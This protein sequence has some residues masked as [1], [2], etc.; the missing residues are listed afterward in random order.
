MK[1]TTFLL[2]LV[3]AIV[4]LT[5]ASWGLASARVADML[6]AP[7]PNM[8]KLRTQLKLAGEPALKGSPRVW[9]FT[10]A[11]TILPGVPVATFYVDLTGHVLRSEPSAL[12]GALKEFHS[13]GY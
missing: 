11:P 5:G 2:F 13:K 6:G 7:P 3:L 12:V 4:L 10:Y 8:G 1:P 9:K